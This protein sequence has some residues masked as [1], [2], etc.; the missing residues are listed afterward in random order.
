MP[1]EK[2]K[3]HVI[4]A[5]ELQEFRDEYDESRQELANF[6]SSHGNILKKMEKQGYNR[7]VF[8]LVA[9]WCR[10]DV[11]KAQDCVR[12]FAQYSDILGLNEKVDSQGDLIDAEEQRAADAA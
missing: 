3:A 6:N 12:A 1:K 2:S 7:E 10:Y 4:D 8:K 9:K 11:T 5:G